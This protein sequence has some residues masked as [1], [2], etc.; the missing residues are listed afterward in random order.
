MRYLVRGSEAVP[1]EGDL[2]LKRLVVLEFP[3]MQSAEAFYSSP[4]YQPVL[5]LRLRSAHTS[6]ASVQGY[7]G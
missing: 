6:L 5:D 1:K 2:R 4:E 3:D 7:E